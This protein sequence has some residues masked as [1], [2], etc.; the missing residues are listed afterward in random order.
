ML[1]VVMQSDRKK[2]RV[3]GNLLHLTGIR[4]I[5]IAG[6]EVRLTTPSKVYITV[7]MAEEIITL[8]T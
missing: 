2:R 3:G 6:L 8:Q 1:N 4:L 5:S 7:H